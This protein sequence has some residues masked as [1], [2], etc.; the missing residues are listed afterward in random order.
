MVKEL[1]EYSAFAEAANSAKTLNG[2]WKKARL[3]P[4]PPRKIDD[5]IGW[6]RMMQN[7]V[8]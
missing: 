2:P 1:P 4:K 3:R 8:D 5:W 7:A 6:F